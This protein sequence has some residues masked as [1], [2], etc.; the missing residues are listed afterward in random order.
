MEHQH[1]HERS[2]FGFDGA[3]VALA[4]AELLDYLS[5]D[6]SQ[7]QEWTEADVRAIEDLAT[8]DRAAQ[9]IGWS[10]TDESEQ[11]SEQRLQRLRR[12]QSQ[13][14]R[15]NGALPFAEAEREWLIDAYRAS[16]LSHGS[17][18]EVPR[19]MSVKEESILI[20]GVRT[21][22][23]GRELLARWRTW[24]AEQGS[25]AGQGAL[26]VARQTLHEMIITTDPAILIPKSYDAPTDG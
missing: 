10:P 19:N 11:A 16:Q 5:R 15:F 23:T 12:F 8:L 22:T 26:L 20:S 3:E 14:A 21:L 18:T 7:T 1:S 9:D 2:I 24:C 25:Y 13:R 6:H 17:L 4:A